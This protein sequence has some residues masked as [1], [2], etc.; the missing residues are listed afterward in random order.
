M[1]VGLHHLRLLLHHR[2]HRRH[3]LYSKGEKEHRIKV[4]E[5]VQVPG[6]APVL[7]IQPLLLAYRAGQ[8]YGRRVKDESGLVARID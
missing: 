5:D 6:P 8:V 7:D 3:I 1:D 4:R 2:V